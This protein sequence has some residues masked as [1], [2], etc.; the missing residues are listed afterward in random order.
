[1]ADTVVGK[2][3]TFNVMFLATTT[4]VI[5][6]MLNL[7]TEKEPCLIEE[8]K[9][10]PN[11]DFKPIKQLRISKEHVSIDHAIRLLSMNYYNENTEPIVFA[12]FHTLVDELKVSSFFSYYNVCMIFM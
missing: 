12:F 4:G 8:I 10:T 5:R 2:T 6:K 1:M 7:P 9:V 11:G 3:G